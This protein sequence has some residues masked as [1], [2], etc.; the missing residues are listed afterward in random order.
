MRMAFVHEFPIIYGRGQSVGEL[1]AEILIS[2]M[3]ASGA[4]IL[5][6]FARDRDSFISLTKRI[7]PGVERGVVPTQTGLEFHGELYYTPWPP[8]VL[9][10]YCVWPPESDG[11]TLLCDG[12]MLVSSMCPDTKAFFLENPLVYE[13]AFQRTD[14]V[15]YFK[16]EEQVKIIKYLEAYPSVIA[17]F[18][19]NTL[20][21]RYSAYAIRQTKWGGAPAFINSLLHALDSSRRSDVGDYGLRTEIPQPVLC[22]MRALTTRFAYSIEWK[23]GDIA[24][25]D[26]TRTMHAR[27][28]FSGRREIIAVNGEALF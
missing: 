16:T 26:N 14:W 25:I 23:H 21:T 7:A 20:H 10:F 1:P 18:S 22:E 11:Q 5:R 28:P 13:M 24:M 6:N 9:W 17:Q 27:R 2:N 19:G 4:V 12:V 8:D 3:K 15:S